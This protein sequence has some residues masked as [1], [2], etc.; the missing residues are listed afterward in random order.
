MVHLIVVHLIAAHL[1]MIHLIM[2]HL[3]VVH[4]TVVHLAVIHGH[5]HVHLHIV[6]HLHFLLRRNVSGKLRISHPK[7]HGQVGEQDEEDHENDVILN[8]RRRIPVLKD[9]PQFLQENQNGR[10]DAENV[11]PNR[12]HIDGA[13]PLNGRNVRRD[14]IYRR[15]DEEYP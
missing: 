13:A 12:N 8:L 15:N 6:M 2:I 3:T 11:S 10:N 4:L 7:D 9:N 5:I 1:V 14:D